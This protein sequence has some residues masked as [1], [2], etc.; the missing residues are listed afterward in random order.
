[1]FQTAV[2]SPSWY[3]FAVCNGAVAV[4][5]M[6]CVLRILIVWWNSCGNWLSK[7]R[8]LQFR[9]GGIPVQ[10]SACSKTYQ[11]EQTQPEQ[12]SFFPERLAALWIF[13]DMTAISVVDRLRAALQLQ[14]VISI[15]DVEH[16]FVNLLYTFPGITSP[17]PEICQQPEFF[18]ALKLSWVETIILLHL[19]CCVFEWR[20]GKKIRSSQSTNLRLQAMAN[21]RYCPRVVPQALL[22]GQAT[23]ALVEPLNLLQC[24]SQ[25]IP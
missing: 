9:R 21:Q 2:V 6:R 13:S 15:M 24:P 1:M 23:V 12:L 14:I 19:M 7:A 17:A 11:M 16:I 22:S 25:V 5:L 20:R 3:A 4:A 18:D 8:S 10:H